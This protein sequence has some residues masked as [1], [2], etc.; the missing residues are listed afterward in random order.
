MKQYFIILSVFI[1]A[2][3]FA[4]NSKK[5]L[6]NEFLANNATILTDEDGEYSDWIELYNTGN[7]AINLLNWGL[8]DNANKPKK[9]IFPSV[10]IGANQYLVVFASGKDRK[11]ATKELHT[12]FSLSKDGEYLAL[13][14]PNGTI[15]DE[16]APAFPPQRKDV[17]YG[18]YLGE[19][20][21]LNTPTPGA[22]N[23]L[24]SLALPPKFS[25]GRGFYNSPFTVSLTT[26]DPDIKI[27][28]TTNGTRPTSK[29]T[30]YTEPVRITT[31]TPLSAISIRKDNVSS[32]IVTHTYFFISDII[33]QPGNPAGYPGQWG[34]TGSNTSNRA[35]A[36]YAMNQTICNDSRYKN[37]LTEGFL[38]MPSVSIV[39]NPG[40]LFSDVID[41]NEGGIYIY[42]GVKDRPG[43][44]WERP[45]SI[46]YYDPSTGKQFQINCGLRIH[47]AASRQPEKTPKHSFRAY[48]RNIYETGK[49]RFDLF[50][51]ETAVTKFNHL[52]FR[53]GFNCAWHHHKVDERVHSQYVLDS[54]AKRTQRAMGYQSAHDRF[55][56]LFLNGLYWGMYNISERLSDDYMES[57][58]GGQNVDYDIINHNG[59]VD[60][61]KT[62][63]DRTL[64]LAQEGKYNELVSEELL[65]TENFIDYLLLNFYMGNW[66]WGKNNW[67]GARNRVN[68]DKGFQF[69]SWDAESCFF[70]GI[71]Y[72]LITG[73]GVFENSP[74]W[75]MLYGTSGNSGLFRNENFKQ[76]L[77]DRV[78]KHFFNEGVL[79]PQKTAGLYKELSDEID[80]A[81]ILESARWGSYRRDVGGG[82]DPLFNRND[83]LY[84]KQDYL[85]KDYFPKRTEVVYNQLRNAGLIPDLQASGIRHTGTTT[86]VSYYDNSLYVDTPQED[87]IRFEVYSVDGKCVQQGSLQVSNGNNRIELQN[88]APAGIYIY[89]V[90]FDGQIYSG[91]FVK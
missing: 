4:N 89:K 35:Q 50:E 65:F 36:Y 28:Y 13:V 61:Q 51:Q 29:S 91:K 18:Y 64:N 38:S 17:S 16:Y 3:C 82:K 68:P 86:Q 87:N 62:V 42:T 80:K 14:E 22:E 60:G 25:V 47:G 30:P 79:T 57:Y 12:N 44:G 8:T 45:V 46:E 21:F 2:S 84:P 74:F 31:T 48:F 54:F 71:D 72:N 69:F 53:A 75:K 10:V 37:Y 23:I 43:I 70:S 58:L 20:T 6:I 7:T 67:Y 66:D 77:A 15:S 59:L 33:K 19:A 5:I 40:Y 55:V 78:R 90:Y 73:A 11:N 24:E 88:I 41:E 83:H 85:Y 81:I 34:F 63:W 49:L 32:Y 27:Y 76:V 26:N 9:W 39:T 1:A 56:H 52:V